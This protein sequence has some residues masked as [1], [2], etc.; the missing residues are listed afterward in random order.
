[1]NREEQ[2]EE[3]ARV[4]FEVFLAGLKEVLPSGSN[5]QEVE[6]AIFAKQRTLLSQVF[7]ARLDTEAFPPSKARRSQLG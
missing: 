6:A 4:A 3:E 5:L 2:W 7:Q 1:M